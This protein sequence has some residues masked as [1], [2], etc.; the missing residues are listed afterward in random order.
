MPIPPQETNAIVEVHV[1]ISVT[2][3]SGVG[4]SAQIGKCEE[5]QGAPSSHAIHK[6][7]LNWVNRWSM[8]TL[9][10]CSIRKQGRAR[11]T[12]T[13]ASVPIQKITV[14]SFIQDLMGLYT[15][16]FGLNMLDEGT[17]GSNKISISKQE[18]CMVGSM[19]QHILDRLD[20]R[21]FASIKKWYGNATRMAQTS[22]SAI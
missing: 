15:A 16:S 20:T 4:C 13:Q 14:L 12:M 6:P 11:S 10:G 1:C 18:R 8:M 3:A 21:L 9:F 22:L 19:Q 5:H 2:I 17:S 7:S